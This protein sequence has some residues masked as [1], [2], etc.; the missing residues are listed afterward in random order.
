MRVWLGVCQGHSK[1]Y[2]KSPQDIRDPPAPSVKFSVESV[3][4]PFSSGN[5]PMGARHL[6]LPSL[7]A[8]DNCLLLIALG[9]C[10]MVHFVHALVYALCHT[11]Y[12]IYYY[13]KL[14]LN[15][16]SHA[17]W[18]SSD[19]LPSYI[20]QLRAPP[21]LAVIFAWTSF[22]PNKV[23]N[24]LQDVRR[25]AAWC[26]AVGTRELTVYD[27]DGY[28][29]QAISQ[30]SDPKAGAQAPNLLVDAHFGAETAKDF[31]QK[32]PIAIRYP[33]SPTFHGPRL[34]MHVN[35]LT[36]KDDKLV[37]SRA[38]ESTRESGFTS[39]EVSRQL[40]SI[41][42]M[43]SMPDMLVVCDERA[44]P[45]C[46]HGFPCWMVRITT[47]RSLPTWSLLGRWTPKHFVD[48]LNTYTSA[49]QRYGA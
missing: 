37:L 48:T 22:K 34:K 29:A 41:G 26:A 11:I 6:P 42:P 4:A 31:H 33:L 39:S 10:G 2:Q 49:E 17:S 12:T 40:L 21:H 32:N 16:I 43:Q 23:Y 19:V 3:P 47:I 13:L 45:P 24:A 27:E 5:H 35:V 20:D 38:L 18:A 28:L 44:G 36:K 15:T 46:L 9:E 14:C 30:T 1:A 8:S 7:S 25:L